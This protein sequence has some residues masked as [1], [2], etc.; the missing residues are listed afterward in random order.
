MEGF[1]IGLFEA[2]RSR[3][4]KDVLIG[5]SYLEIS[6]LLYANDAIIYAIRRLKMLEIF[7]VCLKF[8]GGL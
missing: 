7:Y 1:H 3:V 4:F 8:F 2:S 6:D 5:D